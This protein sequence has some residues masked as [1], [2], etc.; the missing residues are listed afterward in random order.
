MGNIG[1]KV[2]PFD[3]GL[4]DRNTLD[5]TVS[6]SDQQ[7]LWL[8]LFIM[9]DSRP[10]RIVI[11]GTTGSGKTTLSHRLS[12][13]LQLP[14]IELDAF[15]HGP[16]WSETPDDEFRQLIADSLSGEGW[17]VDGNYSVARDIIWPRATTL[18]WLDYSFPLVFWRLFWRTMTRGIMRKRLWND[19]REDLWRHFLT[20]DS[21]FLWAI[22]THWSR[23]KSLEYVLSLPEYSGIEVK[24]F[25]SARE[26]EVWL[27]A[28]QSGL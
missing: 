22:R 4:G 13:R 8:W 21:L 6:I 7:S 16:N 20:R 27:D 24:R 5:S 10:T 28:M 19:N 9:D 11:L 2:K 26:T 17:I 23:R 12:E 3:S 1:V 25:R 15:R 18:I 14:A